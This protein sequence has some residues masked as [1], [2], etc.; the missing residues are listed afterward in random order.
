VARYLAQRLAQAALVVIGAMLIVFLML[1]L[2][3]GD[4]V[5][6]L[7]GDAPVPKDQVEAVR[8]QLGLDLPLHQQFVRYVRQTLQGDLGRSLKTNRPVV[9]DLRR[10]V[11][12]T[13]S[14]AVAAMILAGVGGVLF[15]I[16][17]AAAHKTWLDDAVTMI[18]LAGISLPTYWTGLLLIWVFSI[19]LGWFP[20]TGQGGF[21]H[22][23]LPAITLGW[24][25]GAILTRLVRS[26]MLEVLRQD[27]VRTARAKGLTRGTVLVRHTLR[28]A[29]IPVVTVASIQL[30]TML[31]GAV[32]VESVFARD[33][34]GRMLVNGILQKDFP[35]VQG[36]VL[37]VAI[38]YSA[39]NLIAD[40][41][42]GWIDPRIHYA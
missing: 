4:P 36:A 13:A 28:N 39:V 26:G 33:G 30:G 21:R 6:V 9:V 19:R 14:L 17:A 25:A 31:G 24:Y 10:S 5:Q 18:A 38:A 32:V 15:G 27:Y 35:S 29:L 41:S 3:P 8:R 7:F 42:Y 37:I 11:P 12:Y 2:V 22:L 1:H 23:V 34:V 20:I 40:I 16:I